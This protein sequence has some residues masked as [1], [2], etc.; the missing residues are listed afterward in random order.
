MMK[1]DLNP[2]QKEAVLSTDGYYLILAGAGSGKTRVLT[3]RIAY[4]IREKNV[5]PER[6]LAF[7]F[8]NKAAGEM[9][10][11]VERSLSQRKIPF[12]VSTFHSTGLKILR[13]E[14]NR[15]GFR[16]NFA[17]YDEDDSIRLIKDIIRKK[18]WNLDEY[19]PSIVRNRIS[20][21]KNSLVTPDEA[22]ETAIDGIEELQAKVYLAYDIELKRSNSFDFDDLITRVVELF[23]AHPKI[24]ERYA[25]QFKYVL[26]DEFQDTNTIQMMMIDMLASKNRNLF[27]VGDDDQAIYGWRGA[28]IENILQFDRLYEG[29]VTIRL[30]ENYR[31]TNNILSA[32]N[33]V[34]SN[35]LDRKGKKLWS[36]KG[37]GE[38]VRTVYASDD[39]GEALAVR[40]AVMRL[41]RNGYRRDEIAVLYRTHAQSRA[42]ETAMIRGG[43]PY[44]IIGGVRFYERKEIKDLLGY[45]KLVNNPDDNLNF[46]RVINVPKR[47][48]GNVTIE[49]IEEEAGDGSLLPAIISGEILDRFS[50]SQ[51]KRIEEFSKLISVMRLRA[52]NDTA[53]EI[54]S[55]LIETIGYRE[56]L[57]EDI[58]TAQVRLENVEELL[59]ETKRFAAVSDDPSLPAFL[60]EIALISNV[61]SMR[62]ED[63]IAL[64]TLHNS[65]GLEYRSVMITGLEEGLLPH[66]SSF[67]DEREMEE[68]RRLFYVGMTRAKEELYLFCAASRM[69]FGNWND[70]RPSRFLEEIPEKYKEITGVNRQ[71][72]GGGDIFRQVDQ[73]ES[74]ERG[75]DRISNDSRFRVGVSISHPS[76]GEGTIKKVEGTGMEMRVTVHFTGFGQKKFLA[77]YAPFRF[78]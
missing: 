62:D 42:L 57:K 76:F 77:H 14:A 12:W 22:V 13:K 61:D 2:R 69:Q 11:R 47:G 52:K 27:V 39:R 41:I 44:Q 16:N 75:E 49:R 54:L 55:Y 6:I 68:E 32:S 64:M 58:K 37:D 59:N 25:R 21:W 31:S 66:F 72:E 56:Y 51:R 19:P 73:I 7:T 50:S 18:N 40:E 71:I 65:K 26:V 10:A 63:K 24:R 28:T 23:T 67:D 45:L 34:I 48:I 1:F 29:T 9:R 20:A 17:I 30:E 3:E 38:K 33:A 35:N 53:Y 74:L 5:S 4:L 70:N 15:I 46:K 78:N 36:K 43:L 8:T 60:E